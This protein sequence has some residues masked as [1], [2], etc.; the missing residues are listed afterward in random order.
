[1][2][3][4]YIRKLAGQHARKR[5][6]S[7]WILTPNDRKTII[8]YYT[9]SSLSLDG[10]EFPQEI[11]N[12]LPKHLAVPATLLGRLAIDK[13]YQRRKLGRF[14]LIDALKRS[15][16]M[17]QGIA[18]MAVIVDAIDNEAI[19]FY[20]KFGFQRFQDHPSR[21]FIVMRTIEQLLKEE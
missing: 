11:A 8:G 13:K 21:L 17:G 16:V 7:T 4:D 18:A 12:K 10:R 1:M 2:L 3:D 14:L 19:R 5:L 15:Y 20:E 9:L 6:A